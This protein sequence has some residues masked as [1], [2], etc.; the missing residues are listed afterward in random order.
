LQVK[1]YIAAHVIAQVSVKKQKI[2]RRAVLLIQVID[3]FKEQSV[4]LCRL[5]AYIRFG[6]FSTKYPALEACMEL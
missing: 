3:K 5:F 4:T 2:I 1:S 6:K